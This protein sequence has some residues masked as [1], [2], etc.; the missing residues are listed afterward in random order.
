MS[1]KFVENL[2]KN[3]IFVL[4]GRTY[5]FI[6]SNRSTVVVKDGLGRKPT[7]PSWSGEMLPRSFDLSESVGR[8]RAEVEK[9]LDLPEDKIIEWLEDEFR[10]DK[11]AART[12]VSHLDE[13][14]KICGF[15]PSDKHLMVEGYLDNRGR[16]GAIFHF[17]FGRRVNDALARAFAF[18]LGKEVGSS[19]RISL[20][21]DAFLLTFP[22]RLAIEGIADRLMPT[23]LEPLLR[24]AITNTE[25]FAQRFRHCANRSFM[26]LRNYKGREISLPRQQLRTSQVLEAINE[27]DTFPMLEEAYREVLYDAFD[28]KNAQLIIDEIKTGNRKIDYRTYS[29]VPS[30]CLTV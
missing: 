14:N 1:E 9:R 25:I 22:N 16:S 11:G 17:P 19:V 2:S 24:K 8:F 21:D 26:V 7:V 20:S 29:P 5:Q 4:G 28:L 6:E 10:L 15:V 18:Q 27:I 30:P 3:D 23:S 12:I 13:Q